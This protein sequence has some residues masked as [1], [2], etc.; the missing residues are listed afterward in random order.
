[1]TDLTLWHVPGS[2][3]TRILWLLEEIGCPYR[4][5]TLD[6]PGSLDAA[7]HPPRAPA[8]R[9][10]A[11]GSQAHQCRLQTGHASLAEL[12]GPA[13]GPAPSFL[14]AGAHAGGEPARASSD[15]ELDH[16]SLS[17]QNRTLWGEDLKADA[18]ILAD[19]H[20]W[21]TVA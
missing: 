16:R 14:S 9:A 3:S 13:T 19:H 18:E 20:R 11:I 6:A 10:A 2:R 17:G 4:L 1:M 8:L 5:E 21:R 12:D 15:P 7:L